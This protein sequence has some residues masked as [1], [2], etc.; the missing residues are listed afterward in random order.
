[1]E[2]KS[3]KEMLAA[4]LVGLDVGITI[5]KSVANAMYSQGVH[6]T[7]SLGIIASAAAAAHLLDLSEVQAVNALA[8]ATTQA[9]GLKRSFGTM[10][11][12]LHAGEAAEAAVEAALLARNGF[13]GAPNIFEGPNGLFKVFGGSV[14]ETALAEMGKDWGIPNLSVKFHA[15]CHW[16]HGPIETVMQIAQHDAIK[17]SDIKSIE[18]E[19]SPIAVK[20][21]DVIHPKTG[22]EGKFSIP[23]SAA[24]ALVT[25]KTGIQGF[26]DE[27]VK[28]AEIA[29]LIDKTKTVIKENEDW[30]YTETTITT[31]DGKSHKASISVFNDLPD[32]EEK[33]KRVRKK[34]T[35]LVAPLLGEQKAKTVEETILSLETVTDVSDLN[36]SKGLQYI[37]E[38]VI[39]A[40]EAPMSGY[41]P[42]T[43]GIT[44]N[45]AGGS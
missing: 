33:R 14:N 21:A 45:S 43:W 3:G 25:G 26:T 9:F 23:Y 4:Y 13:T 1:M 11:K 20:T 18:F 5:A 34:Y 35:D 19:V 8:I 22:L 27:A 24:N 39:K 36:R 28:N 10:S 37:H 42:E 38:L 16:T 15:S 32:L 40:V 12:P 44:Q 31:I 41:V 29:S 6:N 30:F 7:S 17:P 2:K